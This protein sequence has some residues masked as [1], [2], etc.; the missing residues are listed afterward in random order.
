MAQLNVFY[1][2]VT[3]KGKRLVLYLELERPTE[4]CNIL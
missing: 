3:D 2:I 4:P 1:N